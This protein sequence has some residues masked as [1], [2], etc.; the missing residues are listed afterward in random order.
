[1]KKLISIN[2]Y[3]IIIIINFILLNIKWV[4]YRNF[5]LRPIYY[6]NNSIKI[7]V[8]TIWNG[9]QNILS[10]IYNYKNGSNLIS[11]G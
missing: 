6:I 5:K 8:S 11:W 4:F 1:M 2:T 3:Y 9:W 10:I 7:D